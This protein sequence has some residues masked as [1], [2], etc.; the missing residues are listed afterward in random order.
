MP[1][2]GSKNGGFR[3]RQMIARRAVGRHDHAERR[4]VGIVRRHCDELMDTLAGFRID[5]HGRVNQ[6]KSAPLVRFLKQRQ[7]ARCQ[8]K[9]FHDSLLPKADH[10]RRV[11]PGRE[12]LRD[13][14]H[15]ITLPGH[16][17]EPSC[18]RPPIR[19]ASHA[20]MGTDTLP[21]AARCQPAINRSCD[22]T[23]ALAHRY[24]RYG[25]KEGRCRTAKIGPAS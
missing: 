4:P 5:R 7:R 17:V 22:E 23:S 10:S 1:C 14:T 13:S 12:N 20:S 25:R 3:R 18:L 24:R 9:G 6:P 2:A 8:C 21:R 11:V 19:S 16:H 15:Q